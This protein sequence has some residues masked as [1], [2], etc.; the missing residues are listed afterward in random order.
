MEFE[1]EEQ[2]V[3]ALKRWWAENGRSVILGVVLGAGGIFGWQAWGKYQ[4]SQSEQASDVYSDTLDAL[5]VDGTELDADALLVKV[6]SL[7][8]DHA[9]SLYASMGSMAAAR[10]LVEKGDLDG[11]AE[12][13]RWA[14]DKAD[15][16][17][18]RVIAKIR[19]ARVLNANGKS[20]DALGMLPTDAG[21]E[22]TGLIEEARG[23]I[24]LAKNDLDSAREAYKKAIDSGQ[25]TGNPN[26]LTM[27]FN[28]L[29]TSVEE[30]S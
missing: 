25:R 15:Q 4:L 21:E 6:E 10:A 28:D 14:I 3:E 5:A 22:F 9:G 20:D 7:K 11:A 8:D 27:K 17:E 19:L 23:D 29:K 1:T 16:K 12:Q 18:I 2:Q 24:Y 26:A 30:A 13:L